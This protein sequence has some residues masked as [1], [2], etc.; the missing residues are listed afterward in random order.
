MAATRRIGELDVSVAGL[1]C[2]NFGM[3]IDEEKSKAVVDAAIDAG[4]TH[5]DTADLYGGGHSEEFLGHALGS[6]RN[7]VIVATKFGMKTMNMML[8]NIPR[9]SGSWAPLPTVPHMTHCPSAVAGTRPSKAK[10]SMAAFT[11]AR[12]GRMRIR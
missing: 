9:T 6:R 2:N 12:S 7:D 1:G 4:I 10:A 3:R 11:T 5:F 8:A